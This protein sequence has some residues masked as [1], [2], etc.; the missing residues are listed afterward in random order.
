MFDQAIVRDAKRGRWLRF[1]DCIDS[2]SCRDTSA[3]ADLLAEIERRCR[4]ESLHA[5]GYVSY[6]A[7]PAFDA[8]LPTQTTH[9]PLIG[10]ALFRA[11]EV[12]DTTPMHGL[13][14]V[15]ESLEWRLGESQEAFQHKVES[16]RS[17][18]AEGAVYQINLT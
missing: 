17:L 7:A 18:I 4:E 14:E 1:T 3:V 6:E 16:V 9:L 10:F 5:V 15:S 2:V 8:S 13:E 12:L 11:P